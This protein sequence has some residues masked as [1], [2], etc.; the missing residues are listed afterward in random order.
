MDS[1]PTSPSP[2]PDPPNFVPAQSERLQALYPQDDPPWGW[3]DILIF[4]VVTIALYFGLTMVLAIGYIAM[5]HTVESLRGPTMPVMIIGLVTAIIAGLAQLGYLYF[6]SK[7]YGQKSFWRGLGWISF[8]SLG[9]RTEVTS[10]LCV[11]AGVALGLAVSALS[12]LIGQ[13]P[14]STVEQLMHDRQTAVAF[15]IL[16]IFFAPLVEETIFRG[17]IYPVTRRTFGIAGGVVLTGTLFGLLHFYQLWPN[18]GQGILLVGVGIAFTYARALTK[19]TLSSFIMHFSY[20]SFLFVSSF[21]AT[22]GFK[23]IP[24]H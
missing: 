15:G 21:V 6:R 3:R 17:F 9:F 8:E 4:V 22:H 14:G 20:N 13:K 23:N 10:T 2:Q 5:G 18:W 11:I 1:L 16:G 7:M 19:T 12:G 24:I